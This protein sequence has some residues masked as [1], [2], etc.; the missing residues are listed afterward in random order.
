MIQIESIY[1]DILVDAEK[2]QCI[3]APTFLEFNRANHI[4]KRFLEIGLSNVSTDTVGNVIGSVPGQDPTQ[5]PIVLS[6][7]L[8]TVHSEMV[9]HHLTKLGQKWIGAGIGDNTIALAVLINLAR[10]FLKTGTSRRII[11]CANVGEE[12][13]GNLLGMRALV[14]DLKD[15][16]LFYLVLEGVG[17]GVI[18]N[19]GLGVKRYEIIFK[20][21]GGHSWGNFGEPS[22]IHEAAKFIYGF[23]LN[24]LPRTIRSTYNFGKING[25]TTIN[26]I[27]DMAITELDVRSEDQSVL[28]SMEQSIY[29]LKQKNESVKVNIQIN[30]IGERPYG[31]LQPGHWLEREAQ[32][33][34]RSLEIDPVLVMGSTDANYPLSLG[35]PAICVCVTK[36]GNVH[37]TDEFIYLDPIKKGF[38]QIIRIIQAAPID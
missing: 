31:A 5:K 25:G 24:E 10:Y 19:R 37:T 26:S 12:G 17:L 15:T 6:A 11:F 20:T 23:S 22:A 7:H 9:D 28:D 16:P 4:Q 21:K 13:R 34:L 2:I 36:G 27:A 29:L 14:D 35:Y 32:T 30:R 8:D 1:Q 33:V 3:P 18:F 38:L